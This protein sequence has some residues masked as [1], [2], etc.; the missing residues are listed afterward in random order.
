VHMGLDF[1][2]DFL[3]SVS[4]AVCLVVFVYVFAVVRFHRM[5]T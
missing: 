2:T 1:P 5:L 4:A 3:A